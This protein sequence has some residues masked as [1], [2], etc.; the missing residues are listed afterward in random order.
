MALIVVGLY[1]LIGANPKFRKLAWVRGLSIGLPQIGEWERG[2]V[3]EVFDTKLRRWT[4]AGR[5]F[6]RPIPKSFILA[7]SE[8]ADFPNADPRMR[9]RLVGTVLWGSG[10]VVFVG[11]LDAASNEGHFE[12]LVGSAGSS[13][14]KTLAEFERTRDFTL[15]SSI[16][17]LLCPPAPDLYCW[18]RN[19]VNNNIDT[20]ILR[21]KNCLTLFTFI[22]II[23]RSTR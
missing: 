12:R 18:V 22:L 20:S 21:K 4:A 16:Y 8:G 3:G 15:L 23:T 11:V 1:L 17:L 13:K 10:W 9:T 14:T 6:R 2:K 19:F 5:L 7:D